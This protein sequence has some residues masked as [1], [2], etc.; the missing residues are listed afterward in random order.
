MDN[1]AW[2]CQSYDEAKAS[3][4]TVCGQIWNRGW[5]INEKESPDPSEMSSKNCKETIFLGMYFTNHYVRPSP[6]NW[7]SYIDSKKS[8]AKA[9]TAKGHEAWLCDVYFYLRYKELSRTPPA[10]VLDKKRAIYADGAQGNYAAAAVFCLF[11][12]GLMEVKQDPM[13]KGA[14]MET[15]V[16]AAKLAGE[17]AIKWGQDHVFMDAQAITRSSG[18]G[19]SHPAM[20]KRL[21]NEAG[22][23]TIWVKSEDN[24]K[25]SFYP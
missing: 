3:Y 15:E 5:I 14:Q 17:L 21:L 8:S 16:R 20:V 2:K 4:R 11:C 19:T 6:K 10:L 23:A 7:Q 24:C 1:A 25:H 9:K 13:P 18:Q 12:N 22:I